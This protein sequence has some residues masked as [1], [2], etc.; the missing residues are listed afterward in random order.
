MLKNIYYAYIYIHTCICLYISEMNDSNNTRNKRKELD[1][2][3]IIWYTNHEVTCYLKV[4]L[5]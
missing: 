5:D 2:F 3:V 4:D 1:Y